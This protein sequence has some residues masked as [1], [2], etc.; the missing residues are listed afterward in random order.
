MSATATTPPITMEE[1]LLAQAAAL[2]DH[3][4]ALREYTAALRQDTTQ[5]PF[6]SGDEA[7][8]Y[9]GFGITRTGHHLRRMKELR[10]RNLLLTFGQRNPYTYLRA[11]VEEL[12]KRKQSGKVFF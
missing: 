5:S 7:A 4:A 3:A 8:K 12:L 1:A 11:E 6:M 9:L 10:E 2:R